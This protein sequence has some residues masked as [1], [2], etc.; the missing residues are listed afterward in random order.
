MSK[1]STR[2]TI[3]GAS[4]AVTAGLVASMAG[5]AAAATTCRSRRMTRPRPCRSSPTAPPT[6]PSACRTATRSTARASRSRPSTGL[7]ASF[8]GAVVQN[9]GTAM[10]VKNLKIERRR[11]RTTASPSSTASPSWTRAGR[12]RASRSTTSGRRPAVRPGARSSSTTI[13]V[14]DH[15]SPSRSRATPSRH[16]NKNGIDV[17]GNVDCDDPR[18]HRHGHGPSDY[19]AQNGIVVYGADSRSRRS[20]AT[21]SAGTTTRPPTRMP[22]GSSSSVPHVSIDRKN[23]LSGNEVDIDN[24]GT[25]G[26]KFSA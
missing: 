10:N 15:S 13:A 2:L 25:I 8:D 3:L 18:E 1:I 22:P 24:A 6:R 26:G 12:S 20:G 9:D 7:R 21:R 14:G 17:R 23:T 11:R 5:A 16:Y 19:I 4:L